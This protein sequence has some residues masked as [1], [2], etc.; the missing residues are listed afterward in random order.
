MFAACDTGFAPVKSLIE[1]ALSLDAAPSITLYWLATR[2]DGHFMVN[3]CR[4]WSS[5]LDGFEH[6]LAYHSDIAAGAR[7]LAQAMRADLFDI[8]CDFYLAGPE[9]FVHVLHDELRA[10]GVAA[11]QIR[12]EVL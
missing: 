8:A 6:H 4:A 5:A 7:Q 1:H 2:P 9:A 10:A 3:Q 11:G 12:T